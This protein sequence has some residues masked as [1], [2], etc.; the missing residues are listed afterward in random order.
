[1]CLRIRHIDPDA[2]PSRQVSL[3]ALARI[4]PGATV[5][6]YRDGVVRGHPAFLRLASSPAMLAPEV[7]PTC[8]S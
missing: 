6:D 2:T 4:I 1:M 8:P 3:E 7:A 5:T